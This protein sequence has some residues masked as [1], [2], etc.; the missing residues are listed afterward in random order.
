MKEGQL[1]NISWNIL[2]KLLIS[3]W[4]CEDSF[5]GW[6]ICAVRGLVSVTFQWF[7]LL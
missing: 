5:I 6:S 7:Y 1:W 2:R 3:M 4:W